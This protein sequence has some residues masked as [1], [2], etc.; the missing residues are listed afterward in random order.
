MRSL[1][2][3][4]L[5]FCLLFIRGIVAPPPPS[6]PPPSRP[7][8]PQNVPLPPE[9]SHGNPPAPGKKGVWNDAIGDTHAAYGNAPLNQGGIPYHAEHVKSNQEKFPGNRKPFPVNND[10]QATKQRLRDDIIG[11]KPSVPGM[12]RDH[13]P[14][15]VQKMPG[16]ST[17]ERKALSTT[18]N[19]PTTE[20]NAEMRLLGQAHQYAN[21]KD[22][23]GMVQLHPNID[24]N[25][26]RASS[27]ASLISVPADKRPSKIPRPKTNPQQPPSTSPRRLRSGGPPSQPGPSQPQQQQQQQQQQRPATPGP[28]Q[29]K[30]QQQQQRPATPGPLQP[31]QQQQPHTPANQPATPAPQ[32]PS[33]LPQPGFL[34]GRP[35]GAP[36]KENKPP[37]PQ[38]PSPKPADTPSNRGKKPGK[39]DL[40]VLM[41]RILRRRALLRAEFGN[42]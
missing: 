15:N 14:P 16:L 20:S 3:A 29:P 37:A 33:R 22:A 4:L 5:L 18:K 34:S 23:N 24:E 41:A 42:W 8:S 39:R 27:R 6:T 2:S 10:N 21:R 40:D 25:Q 30:Q 36:R 13:K 35:L 28:S 1:T 7:L 26:S 11:N 38:T 17:A 32:T 9:N 31:K 12:S 19:L